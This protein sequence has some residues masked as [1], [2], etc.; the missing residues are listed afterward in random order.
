MEKRLV[1]KDL[2]QKI[3]FFLMETCVVIARVGDR[4]ELI[5]NV[6]TRKVA[7]TTWPLLVVTRV[8]A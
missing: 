8:Y 7:Q 2:N 3:Q 1:L 6:M 5:E 4:H